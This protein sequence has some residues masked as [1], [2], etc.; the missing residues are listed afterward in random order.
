MERRTDCVVV[1]TQRSCGRMNKPGD[2]KTTLDE[3]TK[4]LK[5]KKDDQ[6]SDLDKLRLQN[7]LRRNGVTKPKSST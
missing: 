6:Q 5:K 1:E 2:N 4:G 3:I 7:S